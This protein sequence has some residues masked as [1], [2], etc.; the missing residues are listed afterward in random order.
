MLFGRHTELAVKNVTAVCKRQSRKQMSPPPPQR[1]ADKRSIFC[2]S[3][4]Q[5]V[6]IT[7]KNTFLLEN[8]TD[9]LKPEIK[10]TMCHMLARA[11]LWK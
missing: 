3:S 11:K 5:K 1:L 8:R 6:R 9:D 2:H 4:Q 10:N 7:R